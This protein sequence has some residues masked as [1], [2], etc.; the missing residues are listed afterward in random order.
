MSSE[1]SLKKRYLIKLSANVINGIVN[2]VIVAFIPS[3]LGPIAYGHFVYLQDIF[4]KLFGFFDMGTST[5]FFTKLSANNNR[6]EL[7]S[8]YLIFSFSIFFI[9]SLILNISNSYNFNSILFPEISTEYIYSGFV[10]GFLTWLTQIFVKISDAYALTVS[11]EL[12]K[13]F[14]KIIMLVGLILISKYFIIDLTLYLNFNIIFSFIFIGLISIILL[15][16]RVLLNLYL[17]LNKISILIKEFLDYSLPLATINIISLLTGF[18]DIW[19]LQKISGSEQTAF[20]GLA[21][22]ISAMCFLFTSAMTQVITREFSK[23]YEARNIE[24]MQKLFY[25]YIPML[26]SIT[27]YFAIFISVQNENILYIFTDER[28]LNAS[29]VLILMALYPI[30]QT[31]GQLSGSIFYATNQTKLMRNIGYFIHSLGLLLTFIFIYLFDLGAVG[32]AWKMVI[33]Q[34]IGVNIQL[35]F[36]AK[37]LNLDLKYFL[38]HQ[39]YSVLFF[40]ILAIVSSNIF[41]FN[42]H[43]LDLIVSGGIYT[44][45]VI[46]LGVYLPQIFSIKK[47]ETKYLRNRILSYVIKKEIKK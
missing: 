14:H 32:L 8:F 34:F 1:P 47:E 2:A 35:Y 6:K 19:L 39:A 16:E 38:K 22:G 13:I 44:L 45:F 25:R 4:S 9:S 41:K 20:Y 42:S 36:N 30:H 40:I 12:T 15:K 24:T 43:L 27:A 10:L 21:Y 11:V 5:A 29:F 33:V 26:Y 23:S 28:Y 31:Y 3:I 18:F 17:S 7:I 37:F 46:I